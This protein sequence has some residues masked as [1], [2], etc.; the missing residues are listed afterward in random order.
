V[1]KEASNGERI[2][3]LRI[4]AAAIVNNSAIEHISNHI[5][6]QSATITVVGNEFT[7]KEKMNCEK[8]AAEF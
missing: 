4:A 1:R 3:T 6:F 2:T 7:E 8:I 5:H